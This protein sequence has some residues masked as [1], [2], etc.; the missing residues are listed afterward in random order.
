MKELQELESAH[1]EL[2]TP[3]SPTHRVGGKPIEGF[4][5]VHHRVPMLSIDNTYNPDEL[6][7]FDRRVHKLLP[8]ETVRY[9]VELKIDGG[10][11]LRTKTASSPKDPHAAMANKATT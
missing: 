4:I 5:T 7:E 9:G 1:P 8:G 2:A 11:L 3:D 6:R 10:Y